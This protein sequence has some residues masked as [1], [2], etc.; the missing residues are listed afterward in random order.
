[1]KFP[2]KNI[3][4]KIK[5]DFPTGCRVELVKMNDP[6]RPEMKP[7]IKG[8]VDSVDD[9]GTIHVVWDLGLR[10]GVAFGEDECKRI[11]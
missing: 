11:D 6:Y 1:M 10:L 4:D 7:G 8:V 9:I 3:V 5:A 2:S